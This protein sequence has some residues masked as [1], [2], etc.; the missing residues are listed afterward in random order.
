MSARVKEVGSV[1]IVV[2][3][4]DRLVDLVVVLEQGKRLRNNCL[5]P[6]S[7]IGA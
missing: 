1:A 4:D 6:G 5:F 7:P 2:G 3:K